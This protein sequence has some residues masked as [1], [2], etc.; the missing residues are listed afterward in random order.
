MK[1][2]LSCAVLDPYLSPLLDEETAATFFDL[3]LHDEPS[4]MRPT[5]QEKIDSLSAPST[6]MIGYGL[7]G[8]GVVGLEAGPHTLILPKAHD[9]IGMAYGSAEAHMA[10]QQANPG[11]Y[12]LTR[13][14]LG[15]GND[16]LEQYQRYVEQYGQER[17][18]RVVE[19]F[20]GHYTTVCLMAFSEEELEQVRPLAAPVVEFF[21]DRWQLEYVERVGN[22]EFVERLVTTENTNPED[23]VVVE[24]GGTV[25]M[26]MFL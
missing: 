9:C 13:G 1:V 10:A 18:D 8:N 26:E 20:Y 21:Q 6:V 12:Y 14:W 16:P 7:C 3:G 17:A 19:A 22:P 4:L 5:L 23:F 25:T 2:L 24:P 15:T 11:T